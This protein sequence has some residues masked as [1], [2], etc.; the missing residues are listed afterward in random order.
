[1][2]AGQRAT[3]RAPTGSETELQQSSC[4]KTN[5]F[6][7]LRRSSKTCLG[8]G[9][10]PMLGKNQPTQ[11]CNSLANC[12][13]VSFLKSMA[14]SAIRAFLSSPIRKTVNRGGRYPDFWSPL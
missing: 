7:Y 12:K 9:D 13:R 2:R 1:M 11:G 4:Y 8:S 14:L 3:G 5:S 6:Q 10:V